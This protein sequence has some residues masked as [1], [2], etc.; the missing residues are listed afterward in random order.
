MDMVS[1]ILPAYNSKNTVRKAIHSV[2]RQSYGN[3]ELIV[4]DDCSTDGTSLLLQAMAKKHSTMTVYTNPYNMGVSS[5]RN[6]GVLHSHGKYIAFIDSDD[7]WHKF[8]IEKQVRI[9]K[10]TGCD[11]CYAASIIMNTDTKLAIR[12]VPLKADYK[13]LLKEN[14]IACSSVLIRREV[15]L[16]FKTGFF[17]EDY[18]LWLELLKSGITAI[19]INEPLLFYRLGGRSSNKCLSAI[20]RWEIYRKS[21]HFGILRSAYYFM[22]YS[23]NRLSDMFHIKKALHMQYCRR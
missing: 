2:L 19:G 8:K 20:H 11:L 1:V 13:S 17:H 15:L 16:P 5:S 14:F 9:L 12:Q 3:I 10:T 6:A 7:V 23:V 18:V 4:V 21:E 22:F